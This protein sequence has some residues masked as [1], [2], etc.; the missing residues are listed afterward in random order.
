[1]SI[2]VLVTGANG[3]VGTVLTT[4]LAKNPLYNLRISVRDS[5][6]IDQAENVQIFTIPDINKN[7]NWISA[8]TNCD[9]IIHTAAR[10]HVMVD[11]AADPLQEFRRVNVEGTLNLAKQAVAA[12]VKRFIFIS[13]IK[14]NGEETS[15][16]NP[17][18]PNIFATPED[19]YAISKYEA[20]TQLRDLGK[21]TGME[22]VIIRPPLV[23][24]PGVKGNFERMISWLKKG[25][26]LPLGSI[27]NKRSFVSITNLVDLIIRCIDHLNAANQVFL[28]SDGED[29]S[30]TDLLKNLGKALASPVRL[31][32]IPAWMLI[33]AGTLLG[34][35]KVF[36]RLCGSLQ[37]DISKTCELLDWKPVIG[38]EDALAET[39]QYYI[40]T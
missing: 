17:F 24:G 34:K 8:L 30:T 4:N 28:V 18:Y 15:D 14:V 40:E 2:R 20:E 35:K 9:V 36:Q 31:L 22:I 11:H 19:P 3:F 33:G 13:S 29:I 38:L 7:T 37:V 39:A 23:Y 27:H 12:G 5:R 21:E 10:V 25:Y 32:P 26:P 1:M 16:C 6:S